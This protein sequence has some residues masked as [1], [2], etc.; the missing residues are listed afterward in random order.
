MYIFMVIHYVHMFAEVL[1]LNLFIS[2]LQALKIL[3]SE[4]FHSFISMVA[5]INVNKLLSSCRHLYLIQGIDRTISLYC[6]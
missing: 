3:F 4:L 1:G 5:Y 2:I 6:N